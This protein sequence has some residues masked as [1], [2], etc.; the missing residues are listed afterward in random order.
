[1]TRDTRWFGEARPP[2][3]SV[4]GAACWARQRRDEG[5]PREVS[6]HLRAVPMLQLAGDQCSSWH[7]FSPSQGGSDL[8]LAPR[9]VPSSDIP[10]LLA[11]SHDFHP[12]L[13]LGR[14]IRINLLV[15]GIFQDPSY[16][17]GCKPYG[18]QNI[19]VTYELINKTAIGSGTEHVCCPWQLRRCIPNPWSLQNKTKQITNEVLIPNC[20][21]TTKRKAFVFHLPF[22]LELNST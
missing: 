10:Y 11:I 14:E 19:C 8:C 6:F 20:E 9:A 13:S 1:M 16:T 2:N 15:L 7:P 3:S 18:R 22:F 12:S 4:M 5:L 21:M 17:G